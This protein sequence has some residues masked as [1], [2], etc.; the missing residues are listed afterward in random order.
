VGMWGPRE[1]STLFVM[2]ALAIHEAAAVPT[3]ALGTSCKICSSMPK[4]HLLGQQHLGHCGGLPVA[5]ARLRALVPAGDDQLGSSSCSSH[6]G[7][8]WRRSGRGCSVHGTGPGGCTAHG[9]ANSIA[10]RRCC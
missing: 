10:C 5:P 3:E 9:A 7:R 1:G 2:G 4:A 6:R 8:C